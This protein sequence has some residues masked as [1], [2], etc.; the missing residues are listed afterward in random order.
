[1]KKKTKTSD[2][3]RQVN[4]KL[5]ARTLGKIKVSAKHNKRT[6]GAEVRARI[7]WSIGWKS[8]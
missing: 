6:L 1:M 5:P 8:I 4:T 7:G 2:A 3:M